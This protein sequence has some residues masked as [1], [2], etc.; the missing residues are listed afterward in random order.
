MKQ[1]LADM[2]GIEPH[3]IKTVSSIDDRDAV[4]VELIDDTQYTVTGKEIV[5]FERS[6]S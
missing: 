3:Q 6:R 5:D 2:L 4:I 1:Q